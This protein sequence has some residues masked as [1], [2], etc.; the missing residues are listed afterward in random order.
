MAS[1]F[2]DVVGMKLDQQDLPWLLDFLKSVASKWFELGI[3]LKLEYSH[4]KTIEH[5]YRKANDYLRETMASWLCQSPSAEQL[6]IALTKVEAKKLCQDL[7]LSLIQG[8]HR[9]GL[10]VCIHV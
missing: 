3:Q 10:F 8:A 4:L 1:L 6:L 9:A 2:T 7:K 5:D